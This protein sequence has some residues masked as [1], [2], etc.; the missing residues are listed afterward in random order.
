M[1]NTVSAIITAG[2]NGKRLGKDKM[3]ALIKGRPLILYTLDIFQQSKN[4]DEIIVLVKKRRM[5]KYQQIIDAAGYKVKMVPARHERIVSVYFGVK[6]AKGKY[7]ISHDGNR[8]LTPHYLIDKL[9][10]E[11]KKSQAVITAVSP[12]ATIKYAD[13]M[14]VKKSF[15]RKKTWIAQTP[16]AFER[17]IFLTALKKAIEN[18]YFDA[19]DDSDLITRSGGKVKIIPG[20]EI[21]IKITF[22]QDIIIAEQLLPLSKKL[23]TG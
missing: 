10:N 9:I 20:A 18:K 7:V 8:P 15:P 22:P 6:A 23:C 16:Q 12:T 19:T 14:F 21:N 11:V 1:K 2:G 3:L 5:K 4:I 17:R 13:R